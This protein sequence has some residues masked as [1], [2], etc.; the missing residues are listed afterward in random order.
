TAGVREAAG[1][2]SNFLNSTPGSAGGHCIG[3]EPSYL[4]HKA[5][6][7]AHPPEF[8][9]AGRHINACTGKSISSKVAGGVMGER[10]AITDSVITII[11]FRLK[12]NG[13][14]TRSR[15]VIDMVEELESYGLTVQVTEAYAKPEKVKQFY[16]IDLI[17]QKDLK[18]TDAII[19]A[20]PHDKYLEKEWS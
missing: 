2:K 11:G 18:P 8:I 16:N 5:A 13:P 9:L 10:I 3:G 15:R 1:T 19:F 4:S 6:Q 12:E 20:L 14:D 17:D 7:L